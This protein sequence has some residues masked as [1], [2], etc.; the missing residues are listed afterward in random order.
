MK[1]LIITFF[2][3]VKIFKKKLKTF[4][5][6]IAPFKYSSWV[7]LLNQSSTHEKIDNT[8]SNGIKQ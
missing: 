4:I 6:P 8:K 3:C 5:V 7:S 2:V 1:N